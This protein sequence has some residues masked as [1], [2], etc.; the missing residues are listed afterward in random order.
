LSNP[1]ATQDYVIISSRETGAAGPQLQITAASTTNADAYVQGGTTASTNF[2]A[3]PE[4]RVKLGG[5]LDTTRQSFLK[6]DLGAAPNV[7]RARLRVYGALSSTNSSNVVANVS[8]VDDTNWGESTIT[9]NS[10]PAI[11]ALLGRITVPGVTPQWFEVDVTDYVRAQAA[12]GRRLVSFALT[13]PF[14]TTAYITLN[15]MQA[16]SNQPQLVVEAPVS[17]G[18]GTIDAYV[19]GGTYAGTNF[20]SDP[21]LLVKLSTSA[22]ATRESYLQFDIPA[23]VTSAVLN[24]YGHLASTDEAKVTT[25]VFGVAGASWQEST[26]TWNNRPVG[27]ASLGTITVVGMTPAWVQLDVTAFVKS[28]A[29]AGHT[30]VTF[31]LRNLSATA[32][33]TSFNSG[34][35]AANPPQLV[36]Q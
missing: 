36:V 10:K 1:A 35:A 8:A 26:I 4:L 23:N 27:G 32:T 11:G 20:G 21:E 5:S 3:A 6:F 16:S 19:R 14:G 28:E 18:G 24:L 13:A 25:T 31:A 9:W 22:S 2:G 15:S 29:A 30:T 7:G 33:W 34:E 12:A 17:T